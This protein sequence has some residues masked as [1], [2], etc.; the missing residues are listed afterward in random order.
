MRPGCIYLRTGDKNTPD[1]GNTDVSDIENLWRKRL[2]LTKPPS[3]YIY[4]RLHNRL[5]WT[6]CDDVF[7]NIYRPEYTLTIKH[8]DEQDLDAEFYAYAMPNEHTSYEDLTIKYQNTVLDSYQLVILDDG[9]L[10]I[11]PPEWGY[12]CHDEH[13]IH[14]KYCYKYYVCGSNRYHLFQFLYDP[15]DGDHRYAF[16]HLQDV[17]LIYRSDEERLAFEVYIEANQS[18]LHDKVES[19]TRYDYIQTEIDCKT[20]LYTTRLKVGVALNEL[21]SE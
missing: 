19:I 12:L 17:L 13:G 20:D 14:N 1:G 18:D 4:D 10:R 15:Q 8:D 11:P 2:G 3:E 21:L 7:Y 16:M 6:E 5:E 9:R